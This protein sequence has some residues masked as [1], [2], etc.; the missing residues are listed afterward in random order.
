M[1]KTMSRG[2]ALVTVSALL[3]A[4][5]QAP[6]WAKIGQ[7]RAKE[8]GSFT[9]EQA[10]LAVL[11]EESDFEAQK[12]IAATIRARGSLKGVFGGRSARI[13][14]GRYARAEY[15][16][17]VRAWDASV[18]MQGYGGWGCEADLRKWENQAWFKHCRIV[19]VA[20]RTFFWERVK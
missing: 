13:R 15:A 8:S 19:A 14:E 6:A 16:Q 9:R 5:C 10:I 4:G 12:L 20:G 7:H 18:G 17:A 3:F 2:L 1:K 11:G